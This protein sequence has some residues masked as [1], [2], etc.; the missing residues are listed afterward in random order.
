MR[1]TDDETGEVHN[2]FPSNELTADLQKHGEAFACP[3]AQTQ[4]RRRTVGRDGIQIRHQCLRCGS[5]VGNAIKKDSTNVS[6]PDF[7]ETLSNEFET[8]READY[9]RILRK[10]LASQMR[11]EAS[12]QKEYAAY[13][14]SPQWAGKRRKVFERA[15]GLCEGCRER[16]AEDVHHLTYDH[17]YDEFLFELIALCR[18][19]HERLHGVDIDDAIL[20]ES[21]CAGCRWQVDGVAESWC[22]KFD[23]S[24]KAAMAGDGP[25]GPKQSELEPLK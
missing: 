17:I 16:S 25:C 15:G 7:D 3:H 18:P 20:L 1:V 4:I 13:L 6:L 24:T 14:V 11:R 10:H 23:I 5:A 12:H 19:C 2:L 8:A 21:P 9:K 22:G